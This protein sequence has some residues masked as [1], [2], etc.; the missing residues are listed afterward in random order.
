M[1]ERT[2]FLDRGIGESRG[3]VLLDGAPER[4]LIV[5]DG[6]DARTRLGARHVARVRKVEPSTILLALDGRGRVRHRALVVDVLAEVAAGVESPLERRYR[7]DVERAHGLPIS[8]LQ[9][10]EVL[11]GRWVRAD[12]RYRPYRTRVELDG[13]LA[14]PGGRTDE[15]TWRDNAALLETDR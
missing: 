15:D 11:S 4:L 9:V 8:E 12:G 14:H 10:R 5:R 7:R 2:L 6:D 13:Q 3:V 1:S